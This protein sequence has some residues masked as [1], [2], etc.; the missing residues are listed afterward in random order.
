MERALREDR[1]PFSRLGWAF[2][3]MLFSATV[4][5]LVMVLLFALFLPDFVSSPWYIWVIG[6]LPLYLVGGPLCWLI[7]S[8][9][10]R[11]YIRDHA[12]GFGTLCLCFVVCYA[13]MYVG[14]LLGTGINAL[15]GLLKGGAVGNPLDSLLAEQSIWLTALFVVLLAPCVEEFL[16]RKLI[17]DRLAP[18]GDRTAI[19]VSALV[20]GLLHGNF[21]QFFYAFGVGLIFGYVYI[22]SGRLRYTIGMH[23]LLNFMGSVLPMLLFEGLGDMTDFSGDPVEALRLLPQ[24]LGLLGYALLVLGLVVTGVVL[25]F[26]F[27]KRIRLYPGE[28]SL[29]GRRFRVVA[30]NPGMLLLF[31]LS[32]ALFVM[33]ILA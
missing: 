7:L 15:L 30:L 11:V 14:N 20:F 29:Q 24:A 13:V 1:R 3:T 12:L 10:P 33:N 2:A 31:A 22:R 23:M 21:Q 32:L 6:S 19:F 25:F 8:R 16:C 18:F 5:Q 9:L 17:I 27:R 4:L 28:F 26:V